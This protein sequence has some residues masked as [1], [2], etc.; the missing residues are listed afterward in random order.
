MHLAAQL[1]K[2]ELVSLLL[3]LEARTGSLH[4][5]SNRARINRVTLRITFKKGYFEGCCKGYYKDSV[6]RFRA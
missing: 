6:S 5:I 3:E 2:P 1:G 4:S